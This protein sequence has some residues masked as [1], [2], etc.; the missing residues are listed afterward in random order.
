MSLSRSLETSKGME[1]L[2]MSFGM[3]DGNIER[4][5]K[6]VRMDDVFTG[7]SERNSQKRE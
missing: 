3:I 2:S 4:K 1:P 6:T 7:R 5:G